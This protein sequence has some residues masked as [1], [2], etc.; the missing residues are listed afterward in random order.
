MK[1]LIEDQNKYAVGRLI[2]RKVFFFNFRECHGRKY[3]QK[4]RNKWIL[5]S[6]KLWEI[7]LN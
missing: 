7:K 5:K 1:N 3:V 2:S 4:L 6:L